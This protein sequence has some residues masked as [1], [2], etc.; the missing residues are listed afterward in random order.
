MTSLNIPL[1]FTFNHESWVSC[2]VRCQFARAQ[3]DLNL[4][5][6]AYFSD[7]VSILSLREKTD[8][9]ITDERNGII[10]GSL[11]NSLS[12]VKSLFEFHNPCR[13]SIKNGREAE[14][15]RPVLPDR[16]AVTAH[17]LRA[18]SRRRSFHG[19]LFCSVLL[20]RA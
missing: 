4:K 14:S 20:C 11:E 7:Q 10:W 19:V 3:I 17:C 16:G 18:A 6:T 5:E 8:G 2:T 15:Y 1:R 13:T 12:F 9:K